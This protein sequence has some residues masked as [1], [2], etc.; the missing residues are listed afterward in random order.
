MPEIIE[1]LEE[2][3]EEEKKDEEEEEQEPE[4]P[5]EQ[6]EKKLAQFAAKDEVEA[7]SDDE[8]ESPEKDADGWMDLMSGKIKMRSLKAG[9]G[10]QPEM[11]ED[12]RCS[13]DVYVVGGDDDSY[14]GKKCISWPEIRFRIGEHEAVPMLELSLRHMKEGEQAE[15]FGMPGMAWGATGLKAASEDEMEIPPDVNIKMIVTLYEVLSTDLSQETPWNEMIN[16]VS[17]RKF[18][19][20]DHFK[21]KDYRKAEICYKHG[22]EVFSARGFDP[23]ESMREKDRPK[24]KAAAMNIVCDLGSNLA[25]VYLEQGETVKAK[26][27]ALA[28]LETRPEHVKC[29]YRAS[30]ACLILDDFEECE[31]LLERGLKVEKDNV[32]LKRVEAELNLKKRRY[33]AKSKRMA[34]TNIFD[35]LAY[36]DLVKAKAEK[37]AEEDYE[38]TWTYWIKKEIDTWF[39]KKIITAVVAFTLSLMVCLMLLPKRWWPLGL[40]GYVMGLPATIGIISATDDE[41][42]EK[43]N[44][45]N[46]KDKKKR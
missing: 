22:V 14:D 34:E 38:E 17:W 15:L 45:K 36:P 28:S 3:S 41:K 44:D 1:E 4:P 13:V 21:R 39:T 32:V 6:P 7:D 46:K 25:A 42:R 37:E 23:P 8:K 26:E 9:T 10:R 30:K 5:K 2:D 24:A 27:T 40:I 33:E 20:N 16:M 35:D 18:N 19:G 29:L 43:M 12:C 11:K 31:Q